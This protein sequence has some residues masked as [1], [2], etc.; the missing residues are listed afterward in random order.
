MNEL[1]KYSKIHVVDLSDVLGENQVL[2]LIP[3]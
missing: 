3:T 1:K 2:E